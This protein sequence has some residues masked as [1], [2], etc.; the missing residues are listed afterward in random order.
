MLSYGQFIQ[1]DKEGIAVAKI[2]TRIASNVK[3]KELINTRRGELVEAAV[4]LFVEKGFHKTTVR[5]I[6]KEFGMSMGTKFCVISDEDLDDIICSI[7]QQ[8]PECGQKMMQGH[9][10]ERGIVVQ[11]TRVRESMRRTDP[12]GTKQRLKIAVRRRQYNVGFPMELW[13]MDGNHKLVR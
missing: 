10:K 12:A 6:A 8:Y 9:L 13:H 1:T 2:K 5:E 11:Q 7:M 3:D 4:K